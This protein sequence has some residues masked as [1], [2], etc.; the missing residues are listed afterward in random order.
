VV[1]AVLCVEAGQPCLTRQVRSGCQPCGGISPTGDNGCVERPTIIELARRAADLTQAEL[2]RRAATTQSAVSMYERRRKVPLLDIAERLMQAAGAD[3]GM[4]TTVVWEVDFLPGLK[5]FHYP[6]RLWR[7]EV[8]GCFDIVRM[9]DMV[10]RTDQGEWNLRDRSDRP[11]LYENLLV[12]GDQHMIMRWVD[13]ALLV[14]V[15]TELVLPAKIRAAWEPA[16]AAA[17]TG[18]SRGVFDA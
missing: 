7:V 14:D 3:L 9:P 10:G 5:P 8:P 1:V 15:W 16:V 18:R 13:G 17:S 12:E 11:R 2:A 4:V 6:N